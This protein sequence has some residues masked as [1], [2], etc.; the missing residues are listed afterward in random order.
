MHDG[1]GGVGPFPSF[2]RLDCNQELSEEAW[3]M[4]LDYER[5]C[6]RVDPARPDPKPAPVPPP[7]PGPSPGSNHAGSSTPSP[8]AQKNYPY[9]NNDDDTSTDDLFPN[10]SGSKKYVPR[11]AKNKSHAGK[12]FKFVFFCLLAGGVYWY[13]K[14]RYDGDF[15]LSLGSICNRNNINLNQFRRTRNFGG[16]DN[17]GLYDSLNMDMAQSSFQP[18]SLPPP[19]SAYDYGPNGGASVNTSGSINGFA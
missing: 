11:E 19:P 6:L 13:F 16:A 10:D 3:G 7:A 18:P 1:C 5:N 17:D 8:S 15:S 14:N 4:Y 9:K 12:F 2:R